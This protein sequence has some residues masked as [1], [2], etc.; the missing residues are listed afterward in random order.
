M[1]EY[2]IEVR[3]HTLDPDDLVSDPDAFADSL[4]DV[5]AEWDGIV[6]AD[7][8]C[9]SLTF[10]VEAQGPR[11]AL[12]TAWDLLAKF[13]DHVAIHMPRWPIL[14][15]R[16]TDA[17]L[18]DFEHSQPNAPDLVSGPE[19]AAILGVS[20]QRVHRLAATHKGFP[21]PL[22]QLAAGSLWTRPAIEAF[23]ESWDRKPGRPRKV[24]A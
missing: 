20:K 4:M 9:W 15:V 19:A 11:Q 21:R 7:Q 13:T 14:D 5:T 1:D 3:A 12:D 22:Y 18:V 24:S 6:A 17:R 23:K 10:T 16:A 8:G 2:V